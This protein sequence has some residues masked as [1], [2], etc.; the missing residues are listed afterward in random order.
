MKPLPVILIVTS[1][2]VCPAWGQS[3]VERR[4]AK[5]RAVR[6][7]QVGENLLKWDASLPDGGWSRWWAQSE[8]APGFAVDWARGAKGAGAL[9]L[10]GQGRR[11]VLGGW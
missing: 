4:K 11:H 6:Q 3:T 10:T 2:L 9:V 7:S 8:K 5:A 1:L